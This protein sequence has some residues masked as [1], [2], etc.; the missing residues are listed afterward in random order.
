[1]FK[2]C[3]NWGCKKRVIFDFQLK[4]P[5]IYLVGGKTMTNRK[6]KL[7]KSCIKKVEMVSK[8]MRN[9]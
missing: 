2:R 9:V 6:M 5:V 4:Y 3:E 1:M 8:E 7:C